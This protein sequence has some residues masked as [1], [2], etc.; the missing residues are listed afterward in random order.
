MKSFKEIHEFEDRL[1]ESQKIREKYPSRI[2]I[3]V[4]NIVD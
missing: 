4:E 2:P 3:I 1:K